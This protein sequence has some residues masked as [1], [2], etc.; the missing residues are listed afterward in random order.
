MEVVVVQGCWVS[1][2]WFQRGTYLSRLSK[3]L[4]YRNL[5]LFLSNRFIF[6]PLSEPEVPFTESQLIW[7]C[8]A[9]KKKKKKNVH[10][11]TNMSIFLCQTVVYKY[12]QSDLIPALQMTRWSKKNIG[13]YLLTSW[14][15]LR[16]YYFSVNLHLVFPRTVRTA[17]V[18]PQSQ[19]NY[20]LWKYF[21][22]VHHE[23]QSKEGLTAELT[24]KLNI[25]FV[26][27]QP[28]ELLCK[29][30]LRQLGVVDVRGSSQLDWSCF[31]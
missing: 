7:F 19:C 25:T 4:K 21:W 2:I 23:L 29:V 22:E 30:Y 26:S 24:D 14:L 5:F 20:Y 28:L 1:V 12:Q 8:W 11:P 15:I 18:H 6:F 10:Q 16:I 17:C 3:T 31:N 9:S 27:Q 13:S